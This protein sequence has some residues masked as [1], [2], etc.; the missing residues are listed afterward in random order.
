MIGFIIFFI[1]TLSCCSI[2]NKDNLN[3]G[4]YDDIL[5]HN[6]NPERH[7][8]FNDNNYQTFRNSKKQI[9]K[10]NN[11]NDQIYLDNTDKE[12]IVKDSFTNHIDD[13]KVTKTHTL[14]AKTLNSY[15]LQDNSPPSTQNHIEYISEHV[16]IG[17]EDFTN[18][19]ETS[20]ITPENSLQ[21]H[22]KRLQNNLNKQQKNALEFLE[23][24]L[25]SKIDKLN[26]ILLL[27]DLEI[28]NIL[29]TISENLNII[30]NFESVNELILDFD[31]LN[32][33]EPASHLNYEDKVKFTKVQNDLS[34]EIEP[35]LNNYL[36][37]IDAHFNDDNINSSIDGINSI[38]IL[39]PSSL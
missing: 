32:D 9:N 10:N 6:K 13:K 39:S 17:N 34:K 11:N 24:A 37:V 19:H 30:K 33:Q 1:L 7:K 35:S 20:I 15:L 38:K 16:I 23:K 22:K 31:N 14:E 29:D 4:F 25:N 27:N 5:I 26:K 2:N 28:T 36:S 12:S 21:N 3:I 8:N 18:N